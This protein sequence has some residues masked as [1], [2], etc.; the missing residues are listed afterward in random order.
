MK[1]HTDKV[2]QVYAPL[3]IV[4]MAGMLAVSIAFIW[5]G[6]GMAGVGYALLFCL[7]CMIPLSR[8]GYRIEGQNGLFS[9]REILVSRNCKDEILAFLDGRSDTLEH[10]PRVN[11]GAIVDIYTRRKDGRIL[12]RYFDYEDLANGKEYDLHELSKEK[13]ARLIEIDSQSK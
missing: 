5:L 9:L 4:V 8:H 11:G 7:L 10:N 1:K 13:K 6:K 12:A 3:D 2:K